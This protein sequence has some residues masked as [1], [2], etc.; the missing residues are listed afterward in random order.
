M[1]AR[2]AA[3]VEHVAKKRNSTPPD[4]STTSTPPSAVSS[5]QPAESAA[6]ESSS[7]SA[8]ASASL[9]K[10]LQPGQPLPTVEKPQSEDLSSKEF[11][12]IQERYLFAGLF[13]MLH[14]VVLISVYLVV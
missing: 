1:P 5:P 11:Q 9:P 10:S 4:V 2:A 14:V 3:R 6:Q 8:S 13:M 7:T 12:S